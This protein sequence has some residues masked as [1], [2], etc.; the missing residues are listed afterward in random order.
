MKLFGYALDWTDYL[1]T[2]SAAVL[3]GDKLFVSANLPV[4]VYVIPAVV[5]VIAK[6]LRVGSYLFGGYEDFRWF[7]FY[8]SVAGVSGYASYS[9]FI[10]GGDV[11]EMRAYVTIAGFFLTIIVYEVA[12][13]ILSGDIRRMTADEAIAASE[14]SRRSLQIGEMPGT[15]SKYT[16]DIVM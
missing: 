8:F 16:G 4:Y 9:Y 3:T 13:S 10:V 5:F 14:K 1:I 7:L 6:F 12:E 15:I 2:L 11:G